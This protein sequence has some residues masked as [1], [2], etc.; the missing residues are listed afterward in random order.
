M[1]TCRGPGCHSAL[2]CFPFNATNIYA[3]GASLLGCGPGPASYRVTSATFL[4][5]PGPRFPDTDGTF[6]RQLPWAELSES[7]SHRGWLLGAPPGAGPR[8]CELEYVFDA[9][10][11]GTS[12]CNDGLVSDGKLI[13]VGHI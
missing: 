1:A 4:N 10:T 8:A 13:N 7:T 6:L 11:W 12:L 2:A 5:L 3:L 9:R